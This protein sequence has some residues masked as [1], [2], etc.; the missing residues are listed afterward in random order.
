[1]DFNALTSRKV[2]GI[3]VVYFI[4]I[5]AAA[6]LYGAF[7][8]K[9]SAPEVTP[10]ESVDGP[11][12]GG[13]AG[14][15]SQPVFQATPVITQPS[16]SQG[17]VASVTSPDTDSLW[18]RR[19]I[20]YLISPAGGYSLDVATAA[21]THY[22]AG[23]PMSNVEAGARDK[24]VQ[25]FGIPPESTPLSTVETPVT[26]VYNGPAS[27]QGVPPCKHTVKGTSDNTYT[28]LASLYYGGNLQS[29]LTLIHANN[30]GLNSPFKVGT[31]VNIPKL[32]QPKYYK[33][34]AATRDAYAIARKNATTPGIV[35][36]LNPG[37]HFPVKI[38][39][40]VR[41]A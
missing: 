19:A 38:G 4:L 33:A 5:L 40:R 3:P 22:L 17:S 14:D 10:A 32:V 36:G 31:I 18:S 41:V 34:T 25:Q 26:P 30:P 39:A 20:E 23:E 6:G 35:V 2:A 1:M 11:D 37:M 21:I 15:T 16:G 13:D 24:A 7:R 12:I 29:M 28:E 27:K 8:L 9:P